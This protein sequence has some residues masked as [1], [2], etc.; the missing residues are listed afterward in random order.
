MRLLCTLILSFCALGLRA[1]TPERWFDKPKSPRIAN[2][3][4]EAVLDWQQKSLEGRETISWRNAG[5]APTSEFPL[6]LYMNAFKGPQTLFMRGQQKAAPGEAQAWGY[7]RLKAVEMDGKPLGGYDGADE[8]VYWV[9]LPR[10]VAPGESIQVKVT[11]E[12]RFPKVIARAGWGGDFLMVAQ[13]FPKVGVYQMDRWTCDPYYP[14]T[15]F[16]ADFGTYDIELSLPNLLSVA[17]TGMAIPQGRFDAKPDPQRKLN[18]VWALHAEDVHDFAFAVM[19]SRSWSFRKFEARGTEIY[20]YYQPEHRASVE[21]IHQAIKGSL[22]AAGE[23]YIPYP[24]PSLTLVDVPPEASAAEGMEYPTLVTIS[25]PT[26]D[27]FLQRLIPEGVTIHEFGHQVF[28]GMLASNEVEEPWLDEGLTS[29]F[30]HR[31]TERLYS[32]LFAS[33]RFQVDS[34]FG[35]WV[36]YWSLPD[37]DPVTR[38]G[39][40]FTSGHAYSVAAY[41]KPVMIFS[42]LEAMLGRPVLDEALRAYAEEMAFKHP[43]A[44][45]LRRVLE[46]VSGRDLSAF[47]RDYVEGTGVMDYTIGRVNNGTVLQ[48]GWVRKGQELTFTPPVPMG[49]GQQGEVTLVRHGSL[50]A[51]V[52]LWVRLEDK[53]ERRVVWDGQDRWTTFT[54]ESPVVAA[55]LDPDGNHPMLKDR[56]HASWTATPPRRGFHYWAQMAWGGLLSLLQGAGIS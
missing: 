1:W 5:T 41:A 26:F 11:W 16:F 19:P 43:T 53:T 36:N 37:R 52:T 6:H 2:Y 31:A 55:M 17:H 32:N 50:V 47:W 20:L 35:E 18:H 10:A 30:T 42:Q 23:W 49:G 14:H 46:R 4:I 27:P 44:K 54:F 24:Y 39:R 51:P 29:W 9:K 28:Q 34:A 25:A 33:R 40:L 56:L 15:E 12:T 3:R 8:T 38:P 13:W 21:R 22:R 7:C 48:G 45:D